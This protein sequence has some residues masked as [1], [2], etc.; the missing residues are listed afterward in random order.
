MVAGDVMRHEGWQRL[1][2]EYAKQFEAETPK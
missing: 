1:R 2:A